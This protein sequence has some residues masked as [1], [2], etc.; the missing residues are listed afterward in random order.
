MSLLVVVVPSPS[1]VVVDIGFLVPPSN[2]LFIAV[3]GLLSILTPEAN[4]I[5]H[6][7]WRW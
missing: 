3:L 5:L 2:T 7:L 4:L 6:C 1:P